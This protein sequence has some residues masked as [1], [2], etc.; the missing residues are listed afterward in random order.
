LLA[1]VLVAFLDA[2]PSNRE[3]RYP[4]AQQTTYG[5]KYGCH[6][7]GMIHTADLTAACMCNFILFGS[8]AECSRA[9]PRAR[10]RVSCVSCVYAFPTLWEVD[11]VHDGVC[12]SRARLWLAA[13]LCVRA[14]RA[15]RFNEM[16][17]ALFTYVHHS[18]QPRH[19]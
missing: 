1:A 3:D 7:G 15:A 17:R 16:G 6:R 18:V 13:W 5:E 10:A 12:V 2:H 14:G 4:K 9:R 19:S 8:K 11:P